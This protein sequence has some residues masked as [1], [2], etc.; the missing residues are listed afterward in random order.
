MLDSRVGEDATDR[1]RARLSRPGITRVCGGKPSPCVEPREPDPNQVTQ[2]IDDRDE[3]VQ[4]ARVALA[5]WLDDLRDLGPLG[6]HYGSL[7]MEA[8]P[9]R[10]TLIVRVLQGAPRAIR[11]NP[12]IT[13]GVHDPSHPEILFYEPAGDGSMP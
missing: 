2:P 3:P 10:D 4:R 13:D 12:A 1:P 6:R 11:R 9:A 8:A 5:H 7:G